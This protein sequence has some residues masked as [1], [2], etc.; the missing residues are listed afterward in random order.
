MTMSQPDTDKA[1]R[2]AE[3]SS[4]IALRVRLSCYILDLERLA[5]YI[6]LGLAKYILLGLAPSS[7][8]A[9]FRVV[10]VRDGRTRT[11]IRDGKKSHLTISGIP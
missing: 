8:F 11:K 4:V 5:K 10:R 7:F 3:N 1:L 2:E 9:L 6:L